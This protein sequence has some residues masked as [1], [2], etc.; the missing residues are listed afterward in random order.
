MYVA[1]LAGA[2]GL[3]VRFLGCV[4]RF[5]IWDKDDLIDQF[6][7]DADVGESH[8]IL[9]HAPADVVFDVARNF[10]LLSIPLVHAIFRLREIVFRVKTTP[11]LE[12][13]SIVDETMAMGWRLLAERPGRE[14]VMGAVTQPWLGDVKFRGLS[15]D[16]FVAFAEPD[17]VKIAWTLEAEPCG[18]AVSLFRTQTRVLA[19]D[20]RARR[21]F[22]LYWLFAGTFIV[23]IRRLGNRAIRRE[24]ENRVSRSVHAGKHERLR[25][26][27]GDEFIP[28]PVGCLTHGITI[29]RAPK[30]VWPWLVQMGAGRAG[31]YS[32]DFIDNGGTHSA[33][34]I[35][36]E[37]QNVK[38]G[39][40]F[41]ALPGIRDG[42]T[43]LAF[44]PVRSLI[45]GWRAPDGRLLSTWAFVLEE[46]QNRRTRLLVRV[47]GGAGY[48]FHGLSWTFA[49]LLLIPGHFVMERKQLKGIARR[50]EAG[51]AAI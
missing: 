45:L 33:D 13:R 51:S 49:K 44:E 38:I 21:R 43:L 30:D 2:A 47:R 15:P 14:L 32:Y 8:E 20:P 5:E 41:P 3:V 4:E 29:R 17:F 46:T 16:E 10:D 23:L 37:L 26:L 1:A 35:K 9:I 7:A 31:W 42:F 34:E 40:T 48:R 36:P 18:A 27:P 25:A 19:T 50:A 28:N 24:A 6:I 12:P 39:E 11:R 22:R